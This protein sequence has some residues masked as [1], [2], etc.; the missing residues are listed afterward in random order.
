MRALI[1]V[2]LQYD[3]CPGGALQ[4]ARG[5]ETIT[6]AVQVNGKLRDRLEVDAEITEEDAVALALASPKVQE[7][8]GGQ[9]PR[10]VVAR[11]PKLVNVV[12]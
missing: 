6:I 5:D 11:P 10:K 4:V 3:F 1:L 2:D 12:V 9:E 8:L 7:H